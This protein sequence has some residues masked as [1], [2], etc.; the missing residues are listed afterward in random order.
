MKSCLHLF[1]RK[2]IESDT[3]CDSRKYDISRVLTKTGPS[4]SFQRHAS[5]SQSPNKSSSR[6]D[7]RL[8]VLQEAFSRK[9]LLRTAINTK[10][11][12][13]KVQ[14]LARQL[15]SNFL[16][17]GEKHIP[18]RLEMGRKKRTEQKSMYSG[19]YNLHVL[20]IYLFS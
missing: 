8:E 12:A 5:R 2:R 10:R 1:R 7:H 16:R 18:R 19:F 4:S 3:L 15:V 6:D 13:L 20:R 9:Q 11:E 14:S 17:L